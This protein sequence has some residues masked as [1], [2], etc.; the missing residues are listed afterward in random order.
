LVFVALGTLV[1][2]FLA[3]QFYERK[4]LLASKAKVCGKVSTSTAHMAETSAFI[5][6]NED[7]G[8]I[9]E[10]DKKDMHIIGMKVHA[11]AHAHAPGH[12]HMHD[13]GQIHSHQHGEVELSSQGRHV[14]VAQVIIVLVLIKHVFIS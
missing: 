6:I 11:T 7:Q 9:H 5:I 2:D 12:G 13:H 14:V 1:L 3:T 4:Q 10:V 8:E